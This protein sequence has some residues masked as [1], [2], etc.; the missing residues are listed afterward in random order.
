MDY[1]VGGTEVSAKG[2]SNYKKLLKVKKS[3]WINLDSQNEN[4]MS[5]WKVL[6]S[7]FK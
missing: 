2:K 6:I 1:R 4:G 5:L 7:K 3:Q